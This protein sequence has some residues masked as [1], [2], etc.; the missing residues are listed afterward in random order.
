MMKRVCGSFLA[1]LALACVGWAQNPSADAPAG[2]EDVENLF[3]TL[4]IREMMQNVMTT[5]MQQ[6][7]LVT[8]D[9]LKKK[10]PTHRP[11]RSSC[12]SNRP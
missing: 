2:K 11:D 5:S 7:K 6:Q 9:A 1:V 8:H 12:V 3:V 4:H 10:M